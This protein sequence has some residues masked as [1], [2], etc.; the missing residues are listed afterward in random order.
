MKK[1]LSVFITSLTFFCMTGCFTPT[2]STVEFLDANGKV[3]K[4]VHASESLAK[5]IVDAYK[6]HTIISYNNGWQVSLKATMTTTENPFPTV[7][8]GMGKNDK[9]AFILHKEHDISIMPYLVKQ[10]RDSEIK[11]TYKETSA[12]V[13]AGSDSE[14]PLSVVGRDLKRIPRPLYA[15]ANGS[16]IVYTLSATPKVGDRA[17]A[18]SM[19]TGRLS[20]VGVITSVT[21]QSVVI[22]K[23]IYIRAAKDDKNPT[24]VPIKQE[25]AKEATATTTEAVKPVTSV[26]EAVKE[27][28]K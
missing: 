21:D 9:A 1:Y 12:S 18:K 11:F 15:W 24:I 28:L 13:T 19:L 20:P 10:V 5:T 7:E 26:N 25:A 17:V 23:T 14:D 4:R 22:E 6:D 16:S 8:F 27:A 3:I 2:Q